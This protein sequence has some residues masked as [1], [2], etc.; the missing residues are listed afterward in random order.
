M[1]QSQDQAIIERIKL[2]RGTTEP[3]QSAQTENTEAVNVSED[4]PIEEVIE[5]EAQA[6]D[7]NAVECEERASDSTET[8]MNDT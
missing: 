5:P 8:E 7:D 4:T 1:Y 3:E 6:E 2:S